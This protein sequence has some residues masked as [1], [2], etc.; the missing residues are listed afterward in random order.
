[1][2]IHPCRTIFVRTQRFFPLLMQFM[3]SELDDF[4]KEAAACS[5]YSYSQLS[6]QASTRDAAL[7]ALREKAAQRMA[8]RHWVAEKGDT[9]AAM[10][11]FRSTIQYRID[12]KVADIR[13]CFDED[14]DWAK[15][16]RRKVEKYLGP[17]GRM[18]V[19]GFDKDG[20]CIFHFVGKNSPEEGKTDPE[21][22]LEA[23]YYILEKAIAAT[24]RRTNGQ[25]NMIV[26]SV[27][28]EDFKKWHAPPMGV[29]K[30]MLAV[31]KDHYVQRLW[32]VYLID[33]PAIFRGIWTLLNPFIDPVTKTKF[34]FVTGEQQRV[35]VFGEILDKSQAM[36]YQRPDGELTDDVDMQEFFKAP[37][38]QAYREK[39]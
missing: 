34:Q 29:C 23:H 14:T 6:D 27:D 11:K 39:M 9:E 20:R 21:G 1:M 31:L 19:R 2:L 26:V 24:E 8:A 18:F 16:T 38:N 22:C 28:F 5:S 36:P 30:D 15:E 35:A 12:R 4:E 7:D 32:R 10:K 33:A 37:F 25:Q 17:D 13:K 3:I